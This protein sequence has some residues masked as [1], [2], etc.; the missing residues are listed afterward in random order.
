MSLK[1]GR[2]GKIDREL[3]RREQRSG[4]RQRGK[5]G[6]GIEESTSE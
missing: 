5:N 4:G 3:R 1:G 6:G 2:R